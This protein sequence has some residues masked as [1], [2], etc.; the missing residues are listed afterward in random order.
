MDSAGFFRVQHVHR[1]RAGP[2]HLAVRK[3]WRVHRPGFKRIGSEPGGQLGDV[4]AAGVVEVLPRGKNLH[5][6]RAR[7]GRKLQQSRMKALTQIEVC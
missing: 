7:P 2:A 6:L 5:C 4:L 1:R 3:E